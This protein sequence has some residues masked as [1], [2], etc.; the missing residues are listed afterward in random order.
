MI[1]AA[2]LSKDENT[3]LIFLRRIMSDLLNNA[4]LISSHVVGFTSHASFFIQLKMFLIEFTYG[5]CGGHN[6]YLAFI[7]VL[8]PLQ[9]RHGSVEMNIV[10][11][12][13]TNG[14][15]WSPNIFSTGSSKFPSTKVCRTYL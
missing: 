1:A 12:W 6:Y 5:D 3:V 7:I 11:Y 8:E 13:N 4:V 10:L 14:C 2:L 9:H 15:C